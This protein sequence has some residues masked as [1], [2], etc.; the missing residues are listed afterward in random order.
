MVIM[1]KEMPQSSG[2]A[3]FLHGAASKGIYCGTRGDISLK[4]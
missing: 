4:K 3:V 2:A 1:R